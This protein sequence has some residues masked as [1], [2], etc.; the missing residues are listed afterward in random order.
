MPQESLVIN[1]IAESN[2]MS[3]NKI[4]VDVDVY[5]RKDHRFAFNM[6]GEWV[7]AKQTM[8]TENQFFFCECPDKH[9]M[10]LVKPSGMCGKRPFCDYFAH[11]QSSNKKHKTIETK[12]SC[13]PSSESLE[14]RTAKQRLRELVGFYFF[15]T[16]RCQKCSIE[17]I[18]DTKGCSVSIEVVSDDKRWRYDCL[19]KKETFA[20][21]AMEVFHT[22][23]TGYDKTQSIRSSGLEIAEFKSI[24]VLSMPRGCRTK[25]NNLKMQVGTCERCLHEILLEETNAGI[26]EYLSNEIKVLKYQ[27][28]VIAKCYWRQH[29]IR[30][31]LHI[32]DMHEMCQALICISLF[33]LK[34][35]VPRLGEISFTKA[36]RWMNGVLVHGFDRHLPTKMMCIFLV[37]DRNTVHNSQWKHPLVETDFHIFLH[38]STIIRELSSLDED[39]IVLKDCR[40]PILKNIEENYGICAN[41]GVKG[42]DSNICRIKFCMR[43]GR[44]GHLHQKCFARSDVISQQLPTITLNH[45]QR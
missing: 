39:S 44:N 32:T 3:K 21:A 42:H 15:P 24:D 13:I 5:S 6:H 45:W 40:W 7:D 35:N 41:C 8:Y 14:H 10:K 28:R 23:I 4:S 19:L 27:E 11:V 43:C 12:L 31:A 22:H 26:K 18:I 2:E 16:F 20:V 17:K 34:I 37:R 25:L 33:R 29:A 36:I 9:K 38:C 1:K 30:T